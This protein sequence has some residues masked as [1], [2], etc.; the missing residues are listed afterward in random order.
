[1]FLELKGSK[2]EYNLAASDLIIINFFKTNELQLKT[3]Q[4]NVEPSYK[5]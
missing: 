2:K 5:F 3:E 4:Y 1:M